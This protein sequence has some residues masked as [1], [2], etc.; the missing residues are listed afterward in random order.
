M[1]FVFIYLYY[2][3]LCPDPRNPF[4]KKCWIPKTYHKGTGKNKK[5]RYRKMKKISDKRIVICF[6]LL[7][8]AT[9]LLSA[10]GR[11][12]LPQVWEDATYTEDTTLGQGAKTV[13][14]YVTAADRSI[15]LTV[16]TDEETLGAALL[17]LGVIDG[18]QGDFGIYI[19]VV[20]GM[21]ADYNVDA[22]WWGFNKVLTDGTR[23]SMMVGVDGVTIAGGE[24]YELI[25]S[26]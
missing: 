19:K 7:L 22:S 13:D 3:G 2:S 18:D 6:A 21:T 10:C 9:L 16:K 24:V 25:Y 20:N 17:A 8:C 12:V 15:K 1:L 26:K 23:E 14:V 4:L 5:E 11:E